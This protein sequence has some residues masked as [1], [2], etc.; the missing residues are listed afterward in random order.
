M[1]PIVFHMYISFWPF[2][3]LHSGSPIGRFIATMAV[4]MFFLYTTAPL[5]SYH[6]ISKNTSSKSSSSHTRLSNSGPPSSPRSKTRQETCTQKTSDADSMDTAAILQRYLIEII[7][8]TFKAPSTDLQVSLPSSW[9]RHLP[10]KPNRSILTKAERQNLLQL[11]KTV[12]QMHRQTTT[13]STKDRSHIF[14]TVLRP[15]LAINISLSYVL[16]L[17]ASYAY[18]RCKWLKLRRT[19]INRA[20]STCYV[21]Y[22]SDSIFKWD[23]REQFEDHALVIEQAAPDEAVRRVLGLRRWSIRRGAGLIVLRLDGDECWG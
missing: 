2:S 5:A 15:A 4:S 18:H 3:Q 7:A 12:K 14:T 23:L 19:L 13:S 6:R 10:A 17:I 16:N 1:L 8:Y 11:S 9:K 22:S 20:K 21:I